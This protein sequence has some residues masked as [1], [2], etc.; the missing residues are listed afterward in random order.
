MSKSYSPAV[1]ADGP[2]V[3]VSGQVPEAADGSVVE[4]DATAQA[5]QVL[6]NIEEALAPHG[7]DLRHVVKLTYYLRHIADLPAL[8]AVLAERLVH[9]PRP[10][11]TLIE[12]SGLLDSRYLLEIDA[13][14]TLPQRTS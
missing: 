10:A 1:V 9:H 12:V 7:A 2:L 11:A 3:F 5:R 4:G 14:A 6:H 8:R 13:V